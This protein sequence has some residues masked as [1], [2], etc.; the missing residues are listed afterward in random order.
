M[1]V[2]LLIFTGL[3]QWLFSKPSVE[4]KKSATYI[5]I[6]YNLD[7]ANDIFL[8]QPGLRTSSD[9]EGHHC[10]LPSVKF[11]SDSDA[12]FRP[13]QTQSADGFY[14][15]KHELVTCQY[16][17]HRRTYSYLVSKPNLTHWN[18]LIAR[19][20][21]YCIAP[22]VS[23]WAVDTGVVSVAFSCVQSRLGE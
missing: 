9:I 12:R 1:P 14:P 4:I 17:L 22:V 10:Q 5:T 7:L 16:I 2:K 21:R 11:S 18:S 8:S 13:G 15:S 19:L 23:C 3:S 6:G 20:G